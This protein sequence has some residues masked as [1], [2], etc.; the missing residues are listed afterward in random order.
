MV[1]SCP[2]YYPSVSQRAVPQPACKHRRWVEDQKEIVPQGAQTTIEDLESEL[3]PLRG[4]DT[5]VVEYLKVLEQH[6][7]RPGDFCNVDDMRF[8]R[9]G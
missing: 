3:P 9:H 4:K 1:Q 7:D 5:S 2:A 8:K 6:H